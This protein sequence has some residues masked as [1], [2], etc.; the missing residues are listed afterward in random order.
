MKEGTSL[1][2]VLK[3]I[4]EEWI[5]NNFIISQDRVKELIKIN[6]S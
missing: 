1:G 5:N 2:K 4:E 3:M 6:L